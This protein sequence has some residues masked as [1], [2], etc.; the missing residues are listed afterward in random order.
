MNNGR[1]K[2]ER[3]DGRAPGGQEGAVEFLEGLAYLGENDGQFAEHAGRLGTL[4]G[5]QEGRRARPT[6]AA[7]ASKKMPRGSSRLVLPEE[8]AA[9]RA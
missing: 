5:E 1:R 2:D 9:W 3:S 7:R 4:A 8:T 6:R